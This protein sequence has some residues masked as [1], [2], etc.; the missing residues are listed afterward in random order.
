MKKKN[1]KTNKKCKKLFCKTRRNIL[2]KR[3]SSKKY[4]KKNKHVKSQ[5]G[6]FRVKLSRKP[7]FIPS[8]FF[9]FFHHFGLRG[10]SVFCFYPNFFAC[11]SIFF[12]HCIWISRFDI[13]QIEVIFLFRQPSFPFSFLN[14]CSRYRYDL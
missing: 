11:Y 2:H 8:T 6:G 13:L 4:G 3:K 7:S 10:E 12:Y 5:K 9:I 14:A 1:S